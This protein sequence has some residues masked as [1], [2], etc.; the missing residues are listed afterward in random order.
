MII[1]DELSREM[2]LV[3]T[4]KGTTDLHLFSIFLINC[5]DEHHRIQTGMSI[6]LVIASKSADY[7]DISTVSDA[8]IPACDLWIG[9][10]PYLEKA[11]FRKLCK[12]VLKESIRSPVTDLNE[13]G[14]AEDIEEFIPSEI[15]PA[16]RSKIRRRIQYK[17]EID[18]A[19]VI[20]IALPLDETYP[21]R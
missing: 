4:W 21:S 9:D 13:K 19:D 1:E 7:R 2:E 17:E 20:E 8:Y 15:I 18:D 16:N 11:R 10:Y 3:M 6:E 5:I 12:Q 14:D